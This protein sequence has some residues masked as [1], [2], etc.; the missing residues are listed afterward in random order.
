MRNLVDNIRRP[1][2]VF[3]VTILLLGSFPIES[4]LAATLT[5]DDIVAT[6]AEVEEFL[7]GGVDSLDEEFVL[8]LVAVDEMGEEIDGFLMDDDVHVDGD[9][10]VVGDELYEEEEYAVVRVGVYEEGDYVLVGVEE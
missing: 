9:D 4:A 10:A 1:L 8:P 6:D 5:E 3:L 7:D 2:A